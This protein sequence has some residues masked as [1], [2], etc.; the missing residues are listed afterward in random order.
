MQC[1]FLAPGTALYQKKS[2][3]KIGHH[4]RAKRASPTAPL[5]TGAGMCKTGV[6]AGSSAGA[7]K[8]PNRRQSN[9]EWTDDQAGRWG[10]ANTVSDR[11]SRVHAADGT[12]GKNAATRA[13]HYNFMRKGGGRPSGAAGSRRNGTKQAVAVTTGV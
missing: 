13:R 8:E 7:D 9:H 5:R 6:G 3:E 1:I 12:P 11:G 4:A 2:N 10:L